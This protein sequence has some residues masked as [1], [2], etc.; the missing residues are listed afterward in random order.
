VKGGSKRGHPRRETSGGSADELSQRN[1]QLLVGSDRGLGGQVRNSLEEA[2]SLA[3]GGGA[4]QDG[5][6]EGLRGLRTQ[7]AGCVGVRTAP[8]GV[9]R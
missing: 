3:G 2:G 6:L 9:S 8:R 1:K 5:M 7:R 4:G